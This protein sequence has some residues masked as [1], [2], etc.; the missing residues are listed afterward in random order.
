GG[1]VVGVTKRQRH[2]RR[3]KRL[4][5]RGVK[6]RKVT[7]SDCHQF[8][9]RRHV[10]QFLPIASPARKIAAGRAYLPSG[11]R[12]REASDV[13]FGPAGFVRGICDPSSVRRELSESLGSLRLNQRHGFALPGERHDPQVVSTLWSG[14]RIDEKLAI[15]RP[16][17][18]I[19]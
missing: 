1:D 11:A 19:E 17:H 15:G 7:Y 18:W 8:S 12:C 5:L 6:S 3:E 2:R 13:Q 9:V 4:R 16:I 10:E 14:R